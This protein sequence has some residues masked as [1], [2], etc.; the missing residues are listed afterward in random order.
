MEYINQNII[1]ELLSMSECICEMH[2]LFQ[3]DPTTDI[4]S[5]LRSKMQVSRAGLL[6]MMPATIVP[7]GVMG[8]KVLSVFPE[9]YKKGLSSH[10]GI[11]HLFDNEE[12]QLL[13]SANADEITAIRTAAVSAVATNLLAKE[14]SKSICF[15]GSGTQAFKHLEAI[16]EV[17]NIT[18]VNVWSNSKEHDLRFA[19][20]VKEKFELIV[21][22]CSSAKE[23]VANVDIICTVSASN[24]PVLNKTWLK[25]GV[26]INAV[27]ACTPNA[28]ELDSDTVL[29]STVFIDNKLA[30]ENESGDLL[31]P[32]GEQNKKISEL[33]KGDL[34]DL[35]S[36]PK[37]NLKDV[38]TVF[39]SVGFAAEDVAAACFCYRKLKQ[40]ETHL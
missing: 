10:Q 22:T 34:H 14:D 32:A 9:N 21:N 11:F 23:A 20:K 5:P 25:E 36:Y 26:H 16:L 31:I 2:K 28:R 6:G 17:R 24:T 37:T 8:I 27:G 39:I 40:K 19:K 7:Y 33:Y 13:L 38:N 29:N 12:G 18:N 30:I 15:I 1:S 35:V 3:L 4:I